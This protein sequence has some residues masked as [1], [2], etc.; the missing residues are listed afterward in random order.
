MGCIIQVPQ[1]A[2]AVLTHDTLDVSSPRAGN[3]YFLL[4]YPRYLASTT[5]YAVN[6][7]F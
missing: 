7:F 2:T 1:G 4:M 3:S 6:T 5:G